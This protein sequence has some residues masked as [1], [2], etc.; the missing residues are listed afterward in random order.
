M[1]WP[2]ISARLVAASNR[3]LAIA[4]ASQRVAY[5][6]FTG[7]QLRDFGLSKKASKS[8]VEAAG[9]AQHWINRTCPDVVVTER[10]SDTLKGENAQSLIEA[11]QRTAA[12][13]ELLDVMIQR[14]RRFDTKY[15]EGTELAKRYPAMAHR[16]PVY[17]PFYDPE[18]RDAVFIDA[19]VL[20]EEVINASD[21]A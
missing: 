10:I 9:T 7:T 1:T 2:I 11:I 15:D 18:P 12:Q 17:R 8:T 19:L 6:F 14:P 4:A 13:N 5:V 20:A 3:V 16:I 21:Q